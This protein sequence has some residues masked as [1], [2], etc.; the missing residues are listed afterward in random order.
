MHEGQKRKSGEPY[1]IH[2]VA[3]AEKLAGVG[4]DA[5]TIIAALL[6]DTVED[7][8]LTLDDIDSLFDGSVRMLI[9]GV[10]KLSAADIGTNPNMNEQAETLR[11]IFRLMQED[12]RIMV[13]K[14]Y[15]RM[16]N[17][18]TIKFLSEAK[19][20]A[21][22]LE[23]MEVYAK[24]ADRL[25]MQNLRYEL[26]DLCLQ[27][28]EPELHRQMLHQQ[29]ENLRLG[30]AALK[31]MKHVLD[32]KFPSMRDNVAMIV[33]SKTWGKL[34][35]QL[36]I[37]GAASGLAQA[38]L[39]FICDS[40]ETCYRVLGALHEP[41]RREVLSFQD[42]INSPQLNGYRGL[43]TTVILED[44]TRVRCKIR[45]EEMQKYD[46]EG[47]I[48]YCFDEKQRSKL[49][50]LLPWI[51]HLSPLT[52][53][54]KDYSNEFWQ[55]LQS[56]ILGESITIYG[57]DDTAV[58]APKGATALD[59][60]FYLF[61]KKGLEVKTVRMNGKEVPFYAPLVHACSIDGSF[62]RHRQVDRTWLKWVSTGL[63]TS[64]IRNALKEQ[65]AAEQILAGKAILE[66][67]L[68]QRKKGFL[69]EF[70]D[71]AL[72]KTAQ[73]LGFETPDDLY[74]SVAEDRTSASAV[75]EK[76]L[77][78]PHKVHRG[79]PTLINFQF[80]TS[81][82][83]HRP[84]IDR[85]IHSYNDFLQEAR[86]VRQGDGKM[87]TT[88]HINSTPNEEAML[89]RN[90]EKAGAQGMHI[91]R[92][93]RGTYLLIAIIILLWGL[94]PVMARSLLLRGVTATDLTLIRFITF[95]ITA[96]GSF[97]V[98]GA[99]TKNVLKSIRPLKPSLF[100]SSISLF[101]TALSSYIALVTI[102]SLQYIL[103]IIA[104]LVVVRILQASLH[105]KEDAVT[106]LIAL[107]VLGLAYTALISIQGTTMVGT[108]AGI[109]SGLGFALYSL[110]S[111][112]F[113]EEEARIHARYPAYLFWLSMCTLPIL[114]L[115][116]P[117][118]SL[119]SVS[120]ELMLGSILFS[121]V[122]V[123]FPYALYFECMRRL[124]QSIL[125]RM[126]PFVWIA[127]LA[128]D[129]VFQHYP[130]MLALVIAPVLGV[131]LWMYLAPNAR[132]D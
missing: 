56:D 34:R 75:Y 70:D 87:L 45:T 115:L 88:L 49:E 83:N 85:V 126:L 37:Q 53:D 12:P 114:L 125:D 93:A 67:F 74:V 5:D 36:E 98:F 97:L 50:E 94:D 80:E 30:D 106:S 48:L 127:T 40:R 109:V 108:L 132:R 61:G 38:T 78:K 35:A 3:I 62:S 10:T 28:L 63:G 123:V 111:K 79:F 39:A 41:W 43:H 13:I 104:G 65:P 102:S 16:H 19:Q 60:V 129:I 57:P 122:F 77:G 9:D 92:Q 64:Y 76:L 81:P 17:M 89:I 22:A 68:M 33:E 69:E 25:C 18:Q 120:P 31:H 116:I 117:F 95:A 23:T 100:F 27:V 107:F 29:E 72:V 103:L 51:T 2:P 71:A 73:S 131:F 110:V 54:T 84:D 118:A 86:F 59:G 58:Q 130:I 47:V 55:S 82:T 112:R 91:T 15:D 128:G 7:T 90:L 66:E 44:G 121:L 21:L 52:E 96:I 113:Q 42:L 32:K 119:R 14:L 8:P 1:F 11:K 24:I 105:K 46:H 99:L 26:E 4:A 124:E 101:I 6:H 20:K